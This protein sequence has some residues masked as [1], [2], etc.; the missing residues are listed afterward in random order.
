MTATKTDG[1]NPLHHARYRRSN[2]YDPELVIENQMGPNALWLVESL[3]EVLPIEPGMKVLDLGC[4]KALTPIFLA[5]EFGAQV[6]ATDLWIS[7][8]DNQERIVEA[9]LGHLITPIH[10]EAHTLPFAHEF[11]DVVVSL[12]A[13]QYFGTCDLYLGYLVDFLRPG[14]RI[15]A[16]MPGLAREIGLDVPESIRPFWQ[17]EF[18]CFHSPPWW[19]DHWTKTGKVTVDRADTIENGWRDWLRFIDVTTPSLTGWR[20]D[21]AAEEHKMLEADQGEYLGFT[22]IAATKNG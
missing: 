13:Y 1:A 20:R 5:R 17:W 18:G 10:A 3:M 19:H 2:D 22:R 21:S 4:G 9:G 16:V 7:A 8:S 15:G 12:D 11:F 14:G 6:W